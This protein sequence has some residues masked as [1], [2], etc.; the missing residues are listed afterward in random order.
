MR[1]TTSLFKDVVS[2]VMNGILLQIHFRNSS[3]K[4]GLNQSLSHSYSAIS[5]AADLFLFCY[6]GEL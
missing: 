4:R 1:F 3:A 2:V 5:F 6:Y